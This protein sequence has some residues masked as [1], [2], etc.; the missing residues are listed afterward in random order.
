MHWIPHPDVYNRGKWTNVTDLV[1]RGLKIRANAQYW[2]PINTMG[3]L[4]YPVA[5]TKPT[6]LQ[7]GSPI[8]AASWAAREAFH[9]AVVARHRSYKKAKRHESKSGE[10]SSSA[11]KSGARAQSESDA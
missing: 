9:K 6:P 10:R 7:L 5:V 11:S 1:M 3:E 8:V 2:P 4:H